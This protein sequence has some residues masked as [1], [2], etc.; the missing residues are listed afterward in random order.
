MKAT[1]PNGTSSS[2][3]QAATTVM[4]QKVSL[5]VT[6]LLYDAIYDTCC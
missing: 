4:R 1:V 6:S 3:A 2:H 5:L